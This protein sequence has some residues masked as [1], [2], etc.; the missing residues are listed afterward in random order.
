MN[1]RS[2]GAAIQD[3]Y[4]R[5]HTGGGIGGQGG[6]VEGKGEA[7]GAASGW[8][9]DGILEHGGHRVNE[10]GWFCPPEVAASAH[11]VPLV[12]YRTEG[13]APQAVQLER[14]HLALVIHHLGA[15]GVW[16]CVGVREE[17]TGCLVAVLRRDVEQ[18]MLPTP[19]HPHTRCRRAAHLEDVAL[20]ADANLSSDGRDLSARNQR[21][22]REVVVPQVRQAVPV[23]PAQERRGGE[24][25]QRKK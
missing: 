2:F 7:A 4:S 3:R 13:G 11:V 16:V 10:Q 14:Q 12:A 20:L 1:A 25:G 5:L 17:T 8:H 9:V 6:G 24:A 15:Q 22:Q 19:T 18:R 23:V 21:A